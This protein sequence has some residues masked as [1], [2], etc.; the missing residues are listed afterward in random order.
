[1]ILGWDMLFYGKDMI[2][3]IRILQQV[4]FFILSLN[5]NKFVNIYGYRRGSCGFMIFFRFMGF[6]LM[7]KNK[8]E[9]IGFSNVFVSVIF[10]FQ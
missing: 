6:R 7:V 10:M 2:F 8:K 9:V 3:V 5:K 4:K 1:M